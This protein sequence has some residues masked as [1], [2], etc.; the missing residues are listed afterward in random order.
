M[1]V[2]RLW[3]RATRYAYPHE[4]AAATTAGLAAAEQSAAAARATGGQLT[5]QDA[6][7][8]VLQRQ[9][10]DLTAKNLALYKLANEILTRYENFSLGNALSAK[11]PFVG[12]T[13]VKLENQVQSYEDKI[14][15]QKANP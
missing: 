14:R 12:L 10:G 5:K 3:P 13:R 9:V 1:I 4:P 8:V 7:A 6:A 15:D 2:T 11:E